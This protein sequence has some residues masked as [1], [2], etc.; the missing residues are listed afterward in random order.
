MVESRDG[1]FS[2]SD[3]GPGIA[4]DDRPFIFDR[5]WR[6]ASARALPG[7]GLGLSIVAQVVAELQGSVAVD[8]DPISAG[9]DSRS[10]CRLL[11]IRR[12]S[13]NIASNLRRFLGCQAFNF[14]AGMGE[15][16]LRRSMT[17][18]EAHPPT[19]RSTL[20]ASSPRHPSDLLGFVRDVGALRRVRGQR[21][22]Y[23]HHR[24]PPTTIPSTTTSDY[25]DD[26]LHRPP[27]PTTTTTSTTTRRTT[28]ATTG[29]TMA[30]TPRTVPTT[31]RP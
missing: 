15:W 16:D 20:C 1:T 30:T 17:P 10:P 25:D 7:S 11:T 27:R 13:H 4:E 22:A 31:P 5:F 28:T 8:R 18:L 21:R 29:Q 14:L 26:A 2:V 19:T 24:P 12:T 6:S 23:G 3:S 9:L